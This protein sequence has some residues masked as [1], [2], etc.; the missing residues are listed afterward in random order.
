MTG[1]VNADELR[2]IHEDVSIGMAVRSPTIITINSMLSVHF[3]TLRN[4]QIYDLN[5]NPGL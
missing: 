3:P 2:F 5:R 4:P 1:A